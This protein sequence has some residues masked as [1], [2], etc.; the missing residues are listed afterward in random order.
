M[1]STKTNFLA[2]LHQS[3]LEADYGMEAQPCSLRC[4]VLVFL[5]LSFDSV[6]TKVGLA[7]LC[8]PA[9]DPNS[10]LQRTRHSHPLASDEVWD[11][12]SVR[13]P[14]IMDELKMHAYSYTF[15]INDEVL[16]ALRDLYTAGMFA[17]DG[18]SNGL[19][20]QPGANSQQPAVPS[21]S[22]CGQSHRF[23]RWR[24]RR[25]RIVLHFQY[26]RIKKTGQR[27]VLHFQF[28]RI[29]K[30]G[31]LASVRSDHRCP[32]PAF[33]RWWRTRVRA[34]RAF[35]TPQL[36]VTQSPGLG[37]CFASCRQSILHDRCHDTKEGR[38]TLL[39]NWQ[40]GVVDNRHRLKT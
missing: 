8:G 1:F 6:A 19:S 3:V 28:A 32:A 24:C 23:D 30:T 21:R 37:P 34:W 7:N 27:I 5:L 38:W 17:C 25:S 36:R 33:Q 29:K 9:D 20:S 4:N 2:L 10:N 14:C 12:V 35:P 11:S 22:G 18:R 26:A 13:S 15:I 39:S 16:E 31:Q 40:A